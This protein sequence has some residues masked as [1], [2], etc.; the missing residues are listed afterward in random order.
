MTFIV[1]NLFF[2]LIVTAMQKEADTQNGCFGKNDNKMSQTIL[3]IDFT[4]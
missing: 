3:L 2:S 4:Q 1:L